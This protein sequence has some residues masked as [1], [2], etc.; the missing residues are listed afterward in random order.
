MKLSLVNHISSV[1][2]AD[3]NYEKTY[4]ITFGKFLCVY[5]FN[6]THYKILEVSYWLGVERSDYI[7]KVSHTDVQT[8]SKYIDRAT[9]LYESSLPKEIDY[10]VYSVSEDDNSVIV[11][12]SDA[13]NPYVEYWAYFKNVYRFVFDKNSGEYEA[14]ISRLRGAEEKA[15]NNWFE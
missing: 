6:S 12:L 1:E 2:G 9:E 7:E 15:P 10:I 3:I 5:S 14:Y 13:R 11:T 8:A 4:P